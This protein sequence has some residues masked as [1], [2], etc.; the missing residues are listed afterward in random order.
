MEEPVEIAQ[1]YDLNIGNGLLSKLA[2]DLAD[3]VR[4]V[5]FHNVL[6]CPAFDDIDKDNMPVSL[7]DIGEQDVFGEREKKGGV[8]LHYRERTLPCDSALEG[9]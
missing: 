2:M 3:Y 5:D 9:D 6:I 1:F 7:P 8:L 4:I